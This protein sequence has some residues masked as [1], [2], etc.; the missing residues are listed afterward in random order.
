VSTEP[1]P[2]LSDARSGWWDAVTAWLRENVDDTVMHVESVKER[3]W[4]AVLRVRTSRRLL[5]FKAAGPHGRHE[6]RIL[7][8][9]TGRWPGLVPDV[10]AVDESR[11]WVVMADH[12]VPMRDSLDGPA[13]VAV[14]EAV[15]P[16]Y[17]EMQAATTGNLDRWAAAGLPD[18]SVPRLPELLGEVLAGY[19]TLGPLPIDDDER[20]RYV[21]A[22]VG[23]ERVCALLASTPVADAID[24]GD[25]Y[26]GNVLVGD[27]R[28]RLVDW[29]DACRTHPFASLL[30]PY[31]M[32]V[33][34]LD[35]GERAAATSRLR[36]VYLEP[37]GSPASHREAFDL[38]IWVAY[39]ARVLDIDYQSGGASATD[40]AGPLT[41]EVVALLRQWRATLPRQ[42]RVGARRM[43]S[44]PT[45]MPSTPA[46]EDRR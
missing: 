7:A 31:R 39:V 30:V 44:A 15:L 4:G 41:A 43:R 36:D 40:V 25:I 42:G 33:P 19:G 14:V 9:L 27:G 22:L 24:H 29:G 34:L 16:A 8:D 26:G 12:G 38:A 3:P 21:D 23:L 6:P 13:Q 20:R 5:Y 18:R 46:P 35:P 2:W 45:S 32:V 10:V 17:A 28:A 1:A 11:A 37:W